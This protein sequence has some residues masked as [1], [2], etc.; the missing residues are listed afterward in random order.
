MKQKSE[1][2]R[3]T[4]PYNT[5]FELLVSKDDVVREIHIIFHKIITIQIEFAFYL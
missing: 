3:K 5:I 1:K 4:E 2:Q